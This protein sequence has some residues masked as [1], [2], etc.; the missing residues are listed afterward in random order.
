[1]ACRLFLI[2]L[3]CPGQ[4]RFFGPFCFLSLRLS[5]RS[6]AHLPHQPLV[7]SLFS[8]FRA[9]FASNA[10]DAWEWDGKEWHQIDFETTSPDASGFTIAFNSSTNEAIVFLGGNPSSTW[11]WH[12]NRWSLLQPANSA[13]SNRFNTDLAYNPENEQMVLFGGLDGKQSLNDTWMIKGREWSKLNLALV[14][15]PRNGHVTFYD[16]SR[17]R[18]IIF[19]GIDDTSTFGEMY[20]LI[21]PEDNK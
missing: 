10:H 13:P 12:E 7:C 3:I 18:V 11:A 21:L 15:S 4:P 19:G 5:S 17:K 9:L 16:P 14:P 20:E 6:L 2:W 1:M 8:L